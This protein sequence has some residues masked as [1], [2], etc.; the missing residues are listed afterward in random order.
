MIIES[1][2]R[3]LSYCRYSCTDSQSTPFAILRFNGDFIYRDYLEFVSEVINGKS[4]P[5]IMSRN[6]RISNRQI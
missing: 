1:K 4:A 2:R 6:K 5:N 3:E